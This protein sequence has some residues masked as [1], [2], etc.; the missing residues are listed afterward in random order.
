MSRSIATAMANVLASDLCWIWYSSPRLPKPLNNKENCNCF[1]MSCSETSV[2]ALSVIARFSAMIMGRPKKLV[3]FSPLLPYKLVVR[4]SS[5]CKQSILKTVQLHLLFFLERLKE[6]FFSYLH[7]FTLWKLLY[8]SGEIVV[9]SAPVPSLNWVT[10]PFSS[11][12]A[13][14]D[15]A[16]WFVRV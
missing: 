13:C 11:I 10:F 8:V 9:P 7:N 6:T 15:T 16:D 5:F 3:V 4:L 12:Y 2:K 14:L 1:G